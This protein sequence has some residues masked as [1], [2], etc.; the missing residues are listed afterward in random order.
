MAIS[1]WIWSISNLPSKISLSLCV[2]NSRSTGP[3]SCRISTNSFFRRYLGIHTTWYLHSHFVWAK[4][5]VLFMQNLLMLNFERL[6]SVR[7]CIFLYLS[8]FACLPGIAG[9]LPTL[10]TSSDLDLHTSINEVYSNLAN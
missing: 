7:F 8:N 1:M 6:T 10:I 2:A 4:L 3:N 9:G 5:W